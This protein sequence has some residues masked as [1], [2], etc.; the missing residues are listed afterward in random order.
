MHYFTRDHDEQEGAILALEPAGS[1]R[2][3]I[4]SI[5]QAF[6]CHACIDE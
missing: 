2:Y 6:S 3:R 4:H 1:N 5:W